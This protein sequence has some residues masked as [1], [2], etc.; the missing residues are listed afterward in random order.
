MYKSLFF[1][2]YLA[3][4]AFSQTLN[5]SSLP[6]KVRKELSDFLY[7][8][9]GVLSREALPYYVPEVRSADTL[10]FR[11]TAKVEV[12]SLYINRFEVSNKAYLKFCT[13]TRNPTD[14]PDSTA[15]RRG[16]LHS[17]YS[18]PLLKQYFT[19]PAFSDYPVVCVSWLQAKRYC[20]WE[21]ARINRMLEGTDFRVQIRLPTEAEW[22]FAACGG[23]VEQQRRKQ[24]ME[25][26]FYPW[27]GEF[28]KMDGRGNLRI[29]CN[30]FLAYH[31]NR[32]CILFSSF[33]DGALFT[34]PVK[35]YDPNALGLYQM[36]GNANE[37]TQDNYAIDENAI[38]AWLEKWKNLD[39]K[40]YAFLKAEFTPR[41]PIHKYDEWKIIKGGSYLDSPFYQ[42]FTVRQ[43]QLPEESTALTGFRP[44][45]VITKTQQ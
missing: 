38:S 21:T 26:G 4:P 5:I 28:L 10:Q 42:Q 44:V 20:D 13:E 8:P 19:H 7:V 27:P 36:A 18:D 3:S 11:V 45:L 23:E 30:S 12:N 17:S 31:E 33:A 15:W 9:A 37:W 6:K 39:S 24:A 1:L 43:I 35:K 25:T 14:R 16:R 34:G 2:L 22:E 40:F 41:F 29:M 32:D